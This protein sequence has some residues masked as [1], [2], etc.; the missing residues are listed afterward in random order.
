MRRMRTSWRLGL[1]AQSKRFGCEEG[2]NGGRAFLLPA[3]EQVLP[4]RMP[5]LRSTGRAK[6]QPTG[7]RAYSKG[8]RALV[9]GT[10]GTA[11]AEARRS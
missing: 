11:D 10:E 3:S 7:Q 6:A 9:A 1:T 5:V 2:R 4:A 8:A